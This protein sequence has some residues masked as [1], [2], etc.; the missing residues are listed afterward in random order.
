MCELGEGV[1]RE[2]E[3]EVEGGDGG[4]R[5]AH[6]NTQTTPF[7]TKTGQVTAHPKSLFL[8]GKSVQ[9]KKVALS[10]VYTHGEVHFSKKYSFSQGN[11]VKK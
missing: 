3:P 1:L 9:I 11:G 4:N 10:T 6:S 2:E 8:R 7:V 5:T